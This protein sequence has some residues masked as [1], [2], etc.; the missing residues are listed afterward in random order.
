MVGGCEDGKWHRMECEVLAAAPERI[1][2]DN[3]EA[4]CPLFSCISPLRMLLLRNTN[5]DAWRVVD[6]LMDHNNDRD[7]TDNPAWKVHL[8]LMIN[9]V[10]KHLRLDF[11][12]SE[13]RRAIGILRTN[14]VRDGLNEN[15]S[16]EFISQNKNS[17]S[18][19]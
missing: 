13:I 10:Q 9:F 5:P 3:Y 1:E 2:I 18:M 4:A 14:S 7:L 6:T 11:T 8:L 15:N 12:E 19:K 17:K 16:K